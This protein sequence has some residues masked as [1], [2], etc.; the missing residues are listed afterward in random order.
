L[1]QRFG[2]QRAFKNPEF[3]SNAP[4]TEQARPGIQRDSD[5]EVAAKKLGR[6]RSTGNFT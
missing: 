1:R 4:V 2:V 3:D 5:N 6:I